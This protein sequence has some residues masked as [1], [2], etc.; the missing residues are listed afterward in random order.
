[1]WKQITYAGNL[2]FI[3]MRKES[4]IPQVYDSFA[5]KN[6]DGAVCLL[7]NFSLNQSTFSIFNINPNKILIIQ[8]IEIAKERLRVTI[9]N[10][11]T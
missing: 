11:L 1:M 7:N 2:P 6:K 5:E 10:Q 4:L 9:F 3:K 8:N